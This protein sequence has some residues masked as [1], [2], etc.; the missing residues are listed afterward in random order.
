MKIG[1]IGVGNIASCMIEGFCSLGE[2]HDFFLSPR[3]ASKSA[4]LAAKYP[5]VNICRS[6]QRVVD[7]ADVI[8]IT[9]MAA[10]C[11]EVLRGL[12]FRDNQ[13]IINVVA[14]MP[15]EDVR[16]AVG[17]VGSYSHIIPLPSVK[18]RHGPIAAYPEGTFLSQLL[19]PLGTVIF[20]KTLD[21]IRTMQAITALIA[22]FYDMLSHLTGFA[23]KEGLGRE[24]AIPY[25]SAFFASLCRNILD[26]D[27]DFDELL[28][29]MTP[30]GLN[31]MA[32]DI[33]RKQDATKAWADA[34]APA[35]ARIK[36]S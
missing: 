15:P 14:T 9:M 24:Q 27:T 18:H 6:N 20:A 12:K 25:M 11:G 3:N 10:D 4:A 32:L 2:E 1:Y 36:K 31:L 23:E 33:L 29:E 8:F 34:L 30:G 21:D 17:P 28:S 5:N 13:Q 16:E 35:L 7:E 19:S 22:A 26:L